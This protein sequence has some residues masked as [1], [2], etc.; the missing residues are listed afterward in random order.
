MM[1]RLSNRERAAQK[2]LKGIP[3]AKPFGMFVDGKFLTGTK[4]LHRTRQGVAWN[5]FWRMHRRSY[6]YK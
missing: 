6:G 1:E 2:L 3:K 4:S 5:K